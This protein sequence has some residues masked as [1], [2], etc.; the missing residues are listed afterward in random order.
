MAGEEGEARARPRHHQ[1]VPSQYRKWW[2][3]GQRAWSGG[4]ER[5]EKPILGFLLRLFW[6]KCPARITCHPKEAR[7]SWNH[8]VHTMRDRERESTH[9]VTGRKSH[10]KQTNKIAFF[11]WQRRAAQPAQVS[12]CG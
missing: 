12:G 3:I 2:V 6:G 1:P 8:Q 11:F 4:G 7:M 5:K 9:T 10:N